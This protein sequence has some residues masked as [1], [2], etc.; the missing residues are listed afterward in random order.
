M[1]W[2]RSKNNWQTSSEV[3]GKFIIVGAPSGAGKTSIVRRLMEAGLGL[4]FSVSAA[5]RK[6]RAGESDGSDYHFISAD[7]FRNKIINEEL[8]EWQE[9]YKDQYYG[10]LKSEVQRIWDK[11]HHV[12]FDVDV[13][14]GMNLKA[15]Y[16]EISLSL[17][18]MPPSPEELEKRLRLRSTENEESLKKRLD[19]A[20]QEISFAKQFDRI[21]INDKLEDA[22][23]QSITAVSQFL[24][25]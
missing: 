13:Q 5:S 1:N 12:L 22:V 9:V 25:S 7:E 24:K 3:K 15:M 4:E 23:Q 8:L 16:P 17:F 14:G 20:G 2:K 19:K 11:G 21:I 10:T 18:I 6:P